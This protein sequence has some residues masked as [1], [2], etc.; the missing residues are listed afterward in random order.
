[1]LWILIT[2][3]VLVRGISSE[4]HS[5][6]GRWNSNELCQPNAHKNHSY[7]A[8]KGN[9]DIPQSNIMISQTVAL[10]AQWKLSWNT[11]SSQRTSLKLSLVVWKPETTIWSV[12]LSKKSKNFYVGSGY[13]IF[14]KA[15]FLYEHRKMAHVSRRKYT[16]TKQGLK[17]K[18]SCGKTVSITFCLP[19]GWSYIQVLVN[20]QI[21]AIQG[22]V[23]PWVVDREGTKEWEL[24]LD[25]TSTSCPFSRIWMVQLSHPPLAV[26]KCISLHWFR[27]DFHQHSRGLPMLKGSRKEEGLKMKGSHNCWNWLCHY[28]GFSSLYSFRFFDC[29]LSSLSI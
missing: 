13:K 12:I 19:F 28:K 7:T 11:I 9:K 18:Q 3:K 10:F 8:L 4:D 25:N 26:P 6:Q 29:Q 23:Y 22:S 27:E 17:T 2:I 24:S 5:D 15:S 16:A 14:T 21:C 20:H 1:M